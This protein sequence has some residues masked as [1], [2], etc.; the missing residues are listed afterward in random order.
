MWKSNNVISCQNFTGSQLHQCIEEK[1]YTTN[2][3][4]PKSIISSNEVF[5]NLHSNQTIRATP[6]YISFNHGLPKS[7]HLESDMIS[8][9]RD[10]SLNLY[11]SQNLS[12]FIYFMDP[13]LQFESLNPDTIPMATLTLKS[14]TGQIFYYLKVKWNDCDIMCYHLSSRQLGMSS[15]TKTIDLAIPI[16]NIILASV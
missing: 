15:W 13:K 11:I 16:L 12:S 7:F 10:L 4:F 5:T 8:Q 2:D 6:F 14:N 9:N 1:S 3:I